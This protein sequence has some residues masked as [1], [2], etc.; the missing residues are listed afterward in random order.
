MDGRRQETLMTPGPLALR[1]R[2]PAGD[3]SIETR[4]GAETTVD[5]EARRADDGTHAAVAE[6]RIELRERGGVGGHEL[7]VDVPPRSGSGGLGFLFGRSAEVRVR[8]VCP[9]GVQLDVRTK[10]ADTEARGRF[11][12]VEIETV[13]GDVDVRDADGGAR[14]RAVSGD[15]R[16]GRVGGAAELQTVSGDV[17]VEFVGGPA[18][19]QSVSGDLLLRDAASSVT[20]NSVSGDQRIEAVREGTLAAHSVSGDVRVGI[21]RGSRV[22]IDAGSRSGDVTSELEVREAR[23]ETGGPLVE[24]RIQTLSGDVD[25]VRAA[26]PAASAAVAQ[27]RA[28][29]ELP[30]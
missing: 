2:V 28:A 23:P 12:D 1:L 7:E 3:V 14:V 11:A 24:L 18:T 17:L 9:H 21:R 30:E 22:W 6:T 20:T 27:P 15:I 16:L 4:D 13:S 5:V 26:A 8:I 10:S 19:L 25:I 29:G